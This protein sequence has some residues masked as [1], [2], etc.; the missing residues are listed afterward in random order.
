M[1]ES[2]F[3]R[4]EKRHQAELHHFKSLRSSIG[5]KERGLVNHHSKKFNNEFD[6]RLQ[7]VES[8]EMQYPKSKLMSKMSLR[9][10]RK[11]VRNDLGHDLDQLTK[12]N[13]HESNLSP[14]PSLTIM[15]QPNKIDYSRRSIP[16]LL[17]VQ[18]FVNVIILCFS[19][20]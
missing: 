8:Q 19:T 6:A 16:S 20:A 18:R 12:G 15:V 14:H 9:S 10:Q 7:S 5:R 17:L 1:P 4:I 13:Q 3:D 2:R 11:N